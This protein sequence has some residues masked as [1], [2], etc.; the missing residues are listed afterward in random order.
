MMLCGINSDA[1]R[2]TRLANK[3]LHL[4]A[5]MLVAAERSNRY[6]GFDEMS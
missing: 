5:R 4:T 3:A 6:A 2:A 1:A